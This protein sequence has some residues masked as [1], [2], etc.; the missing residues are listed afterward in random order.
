[1]KALLRKDLYVL[2]KTILLFLAMTA[3]MQMSGGFSMP[4]TMLYALFLP[5]TAFTYDDMSRWWEMEAMMPYSEWDIVLSRYILGWLCALLLDAAA[6]VSRALVRMISG[7][8]HGVGV[9]HGDPFASLSPVTPSSFLAGLFLSAAL[10]ALL[11]P[12]YFRFD[13]QKSRT[14]RLLLIALIAALAGLIGAG[15]TIV[16]ISMQYGG[17]DFLTGLPLPPLFLAA[18]LLNAASLPLSRLAYR[19]RRK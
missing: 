3:V 4:L 18:A 1:M 6:A 19:A 14:I 7:V 13:S 11:F 9:L 12:L 5:M 17:E 10:L 16:G 15:L 8:L 2:K